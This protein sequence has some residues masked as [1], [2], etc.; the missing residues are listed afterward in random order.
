MAADDKKDP[1]IVGMSYNS[2]RDDLFLADDSNKVVRAIRVRDNTPAA[3]TP[4]RQRLRDVYRAPHDL[5]GV[6]GVTRLCSVC[7]MSGSDTLLVSSTE[8]GARWLVALTRN[9]SEWREA[10]RVQTDVSGGISGPLSGSRVLIGEWSSKRMELF[11][12]DSGP[13]IALV[14]SI[15]VREQYLSFSATC[16]SDTRVAISYRKDQ[17][18]RVHRLDGNQLKE[19]ARIKLK[20]PDRL[21]WLSDRL[22]VADFDREAIERLHRARNE[23]HATRTPPRTHRHKR[24]EQC[25][26]FV[27]SKR[28]TRN[29]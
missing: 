24:E 3:T 10:Q 22:L 16:G 25:E 1:Y 23:R 26:Q 19:L 9:D 17:S 12:L 28:R 11:H 4:A 20:W 5:C 18:V 27:C 29:L 15:H 13:R 7:H 21:L 8:R 6:C 14:R 2:A